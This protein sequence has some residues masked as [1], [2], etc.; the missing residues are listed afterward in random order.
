M[1]Y[2]GKL[3]QP[4][5]FVFLAMLLLFAAGACTQAKLSQV[6]AVG[7]N[8]AKMLSET[9][10][11]FTRALYWGS[12]D[13]AAA[14]V[15][16]SYRRDFVVEERAR[17]KKERIVEIEPDDVLYDVGSDKAIVTISVKYYKV[18]F[19]LVNTKTEQQIWKYYRFQGGWLLSSRKFIDSDKADE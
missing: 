13:E 9:L 3:K 6:V 16:P 15:K 4:G 7:E 11:N 18:P 10:T 17:K 1:R 19:Y 8:K 12:I 2:F 5:L 14:F